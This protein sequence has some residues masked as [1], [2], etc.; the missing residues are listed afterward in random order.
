MKRISFLIIS[1]SFLGLSACDSNETN[2]EVN[3]LKGHLPADLVNNPRSIKD[4][5]TALN[6]LGKLTFTDT[7][8]N[9]GKITEDEIVEYDFEFE[10]TGIKDILISEAKASCGCTVPAYPQ[11][12]IKHGEKNKIKVTFNS[13]GK[14]GMNEKL[15]LVNTNGNPAV[16]N[17]YI[18][19]EVNEK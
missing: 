5:T 8:H 9:F 6:Q 12:P 11:E 3:E 1:I 15:I 19:A 2:T 18:Q 16:Y 14:K 10:N 7:L 4:D 17:L 13:H